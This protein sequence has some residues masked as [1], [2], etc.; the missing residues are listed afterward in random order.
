M[1]C[2]KTCLYVT[3]GHIR[4]A[5]DFPSEVNELIEEQK[6]HLRSVFLPRGPLIGPPLC[7]D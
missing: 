4:G 7:Q 3:G 5:N 6:Q 1:Q 2:V